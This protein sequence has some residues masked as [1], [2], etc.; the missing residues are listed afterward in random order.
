MRDTLGMPDQLKPKDDAEAVALFRAQVLGP[1][2]CTDVSRRQLAASLRELSERQFFPP[3]AIV[4]RTYSV[5]TL[6][7][8]FY[9]YRKSGLDGLR[10][11]SRQTGHANALSDE[12]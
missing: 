2:L 4:S 6:E 11:Q 10:P 8:W 3:G 9:R 7:R 12:Q 5:S 1:V